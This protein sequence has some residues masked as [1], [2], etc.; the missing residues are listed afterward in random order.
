MTNED[1]LLQRIGGVLT[2]PVYEATDA[3]VRESYMYAQLA[4]R[5]IDTETIGTALTVEL[6]SAFDVWLAQVKAEAREEKR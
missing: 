1:M 3:S 6:S 2:V 5:G 4:L